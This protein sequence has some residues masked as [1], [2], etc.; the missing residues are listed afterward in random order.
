MAILKTFVCLFLYTNLDIYLPK[1]SIKTSGQDHV[2]ETK[3]L[4]LPEIWIPDSLFDNVVNTR[5]FYDAIM[6]ILHAKMT[7]TCALHQ[8]RFIT[9]IC[10]LEVLHQT[11]QNS[12]DFY[13]NLRKL[14]TL[15][16]VSMYIFYSK[17]QILAIQNP[18]QT[19]F[20]SAPT[21]WYC[22]FNYFEE[23]IA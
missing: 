10:L 19:L 23:C 20:T 18:S 9:C 1:T 22:S 6:H 21:L 14:P 13:H 11:D 12:L 2:E 16:T 7:E 17:Y 3:I 8:E 4:T 15:L 5:F